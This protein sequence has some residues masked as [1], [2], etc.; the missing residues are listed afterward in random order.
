[1]V[2]HAH[3][4]VLILANAKK[5]RPQRDLSGQVKRM[6]R[7]FVDGLTQAA[8][9]PA[10]G[11]DDLPAEFGPFG[12]H[13]QLPGYPLDAREQCAQALMAAHHVGQRRAQRI[14][15]QP[16]AQPQRHRHVVNR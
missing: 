5:P 4:H 7:R 13:H 2:H 15:I 6:P 9:R 10:G 1:M 16:A 8:F 11:V 14:G 3:Q 12:P